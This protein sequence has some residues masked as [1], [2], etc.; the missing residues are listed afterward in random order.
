MK[1][2]AK[3]RLLASGLDTKL[4][5][6]A[7]GGVMARHQYIDDPDKDK[8]LAHGKD[9]TKLG[10]FVRMKDGC[11]H[12][13][14]CKL[15]TEGHVDHIVIGYAHNYQGWHQHTWGLK[16]GH[17]VE[18]TSENT[19]NDHWY[20]YTLS[21]D[22]ATAFADHCAKYKPGMGMVRTSRGGSL[23]ELVRK[24]Q[25]GKPSKTQ[26]K[27]TKKR[28]NLTFPD[29][30]A[31]T[32]E[33]MRTETS[34]EHGSLV[35]TVISCAGK[36]ALCIRT[37]PN[38]AVFGSYYLGNGDILCKGDTEADVWAKLLSLTWMKK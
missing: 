18:T 23:T 36:R 9:Y 6:I 13:N 24:A 28:L 27:T 12:W 31:G 30:T 25:S 22:E 2:E 32:A 5:H 15:F 17:L 26:V 16:D 4:D 21:P 35:Q 1:I 7:P 33:F 34:G 11:C 19:D 37:A 8:I 10:K 3:R 38:G 29:G 20:G 14:T